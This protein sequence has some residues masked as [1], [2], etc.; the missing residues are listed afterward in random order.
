M[1]ANNN[2]QFSDSCL[3]E[4]V[5]H[6]LNDIILGFSSADNEIRSKAEQ[7]LYSSWI[8]LEHIEPLLIFLA[9][10]SINP[11]SPISQLSAVLFRKLALKS[12]VGVLNKPS[13]PE[14]GNDDDNSS[15][16]NNNNNN[17]A[18]NAL[19]AK[20][21]SSIPNTTL[22]QLRRILLKGFINRSIPAL[23]KH[24]ISDAISVCCLPELPDWE[25]LITIIFS[26]TTLDTSSGNKEENESNIILKESSFRILASSPDLVIKIDVE[27]TIQLFENGFADE[28]YASNDMVK[29]TAVTA[30]VGYFKEMDKS[31]WKS[32]SVLLPSLLNSL[33]MFLDSG[34]DSA[35]AAV[36]DPL[37]DLV[38]IAPKLFKDMFDDIIRFCDLVIKDK[39]LCSEARLSALEMIV[40][41]SDRAPIM[42]SQSPYFGD[43]SVFDCLY[44]IS[45]ISNDEDS[46]EEWLDST[47]ENT[48]SGEEE[49]EQG[50][51]CLDRLS[52]NLGGEFLVPHLFKY[53]EPMLSSQDWREN[54]GALMGLSAAA[55]GSCNVLIPQTVKLVEMIIPLTNHPHPRVQF[56][57]CNTLGQ[58]CTDFAP[59]IGRVAHSLIAPALIA[60]IN[61]Q[62]CDRVCTHAAAAMVNFS[63]HI[64]KDVMAMYMDDLLTG[65]SCLLSNPKQYVQEQGL[66][67]IAY[68][69]SASGKKFEKYYDTVMPVLAG[70][71]VSNGT[72]LKSLSDDQKKLIG[73]SIESITL[74]AAT[75]GKEKFS[76]YSQQ[77]IEVLL[78]LQNQVIAL[79]DENPEDLEIKNRLEQSWGRL[80][81]LLK[82]DF[83]PLLSVVIP[84]VLET[85]KAAQNVSIIEE[86]EADAY[87]QY[88]EWDVIKI[89]GK[90]IAI[91]SAVLDDKVSAM[92]LLIVYCH[93]LK[94]Y[95]AP[96]VEE[97]MMEITIPS[98]DFYLHD[99]V[100]KTGA[101]LIP[102]LLQSLISA[103]QTMD[104]IL[105]FWSEAASKLID[106]LS[107]E[108]VANVSLMYHDVISH[109]M[110]ILGSDYLTVN[111]L[112]LYVKGTDRN[113]TDLYER[114]ETRHLEDDIY[115]EKEEDMID[116]EDFNDEELLDEINKSLATIFKFQKEKFL[117]MYASLFETILKF[118]NHEQSFMIIFSLVS[119]SDMILYSGNYSSDFKNL[120]VERVISYLLHPETC[121]RQGASYAIG[122]CAVS[123]PDVYSD[124]CLAALTNLIKIITDSDSKL[125]H[126]TMATENAAA[127]IAKI[128]S[129]YDIPQKD[130]ILKIWL[131]SFPIIDDEEAASF[132]YK[133][134]AEMINNKNSIVLQDV[135]KLVDDIVMALLHGSIKDKMAEF[136]SNALKQVLATY[137]QD[138]AMKLFSKYDPEVMAVIS[139]WFA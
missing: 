2:D 83:V 116:E 23:L 40:V 136:V 53:L 94:Q 44:M 84:P 126:N 9:E 93:E 30:F 73:K 7:Y 117:P 92:E 17:N 123:A 20:N 66:T 41:F 129:A 79:G 59:H 54:Y 138:Q 49:S 122:C 98:L 45:D 25:E 11:Q 112:N 85:A 22:I 19:I 15:E 18:G 64:S 38:D 100:R 110:E 125:E 132:S 55:E 21:I 78:H 75:C 72:D 135:P 57:A 31:Q 1:S 81:R 26:A 97:V 111:Q 28:S 32:L 77:F 60:K 131:T 24:K 90:H 71:L 39:D 101:K 69:A 16:R 115:N 99:G 139:R 35:L 118:L 121:I 47:D 13:N 108:P 76:S 91:H 107:N 96:F 134:L 29:V 103:Q 61:T 133:Y 4:S 119:I 36:I 8:T 113:L 46:L 120:F 87:N 3:P 34:N 50:R 14:N 51:Q 33:P 65:L 114:V 5:N 127:A 56:A 43:T 52:L 95:F 12:P 128:L 106:G 89:H 6:Q 58:L 70:I 86:E 37:I 74:V 63:E 27:N 109:C 105:P 102:I 67:S 68:S 137:P 62:S 130:E 104:S 124:T 88:G 48:M 42:C 82:E 80:C 10:Q